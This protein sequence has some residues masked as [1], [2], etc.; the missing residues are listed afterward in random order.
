MPLRSVTIVSF[1]FRRYLSIYLP[2]YLPTYLYIY[3]SSRHLTEKIADS[4]A[5]CVCA[6]VVLLLR[7]RIG[8]VCGATTTT[9]SM[10]IIVLIKLSRFQDAHS[11]RVSRDGFCTMPQSEEVEREE[12]RVILK[13]KGGGA[14]SV[15]VKDFCW[16]E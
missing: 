15:D 13:D 1:Q 16:R 14:G 7:C 12:E 6:S 5:P 10:T 8:L 2:T 11:V 4:K 9:M 3:L